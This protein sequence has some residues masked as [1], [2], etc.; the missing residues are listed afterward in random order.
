MECERVKNNNKQDK[1]KENNINLQVERKIIKRKSKRQRI[2]RRKN[3][4]YI[5]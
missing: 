4:L 1:G 5:K 2:K 3:I